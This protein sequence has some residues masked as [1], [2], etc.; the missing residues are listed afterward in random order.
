[1]LPLSDPPTEEQV[2]A[3]KQRAAAERARRAAERVKKHTSHDVKRTGFTI[4]EFCFANGFSR[5]HYYNL[6]AK[7]QG[8]DERRALGK[9]IIT[10]E[11]AAEWR[12]RRSAA[13]QTAVEGA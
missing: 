2:E 3:D 7:Q 12:K 8:P 6:K 1:M 5:A 11:A 9:I 4:D 10:K 13:S